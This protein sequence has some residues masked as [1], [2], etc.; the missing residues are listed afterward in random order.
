MKVSANLSKTFVKTILVHIEADN[1]PQ[2]I[3]RFDLEKDWDKMCCSNKKD[4]PM[5]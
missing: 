4:M 5:L 2:K 1:L 3:P